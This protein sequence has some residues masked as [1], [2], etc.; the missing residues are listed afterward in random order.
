MPDHNYPTHIL[1]KEDYILLNDT[2]VL[3]LADHWLLR[4]DKEAVHPRTDNGKL[5]NNIIT[6]PQTDHLT[7]NLSLSLFGLFQGEDTAWWPIK[8]I[9]NSAEVHKEWQTGEEGRVPS[10]QEYYCE[11]QPGYWRISIKWLHGRKFTVDGKEYKCSIKHAPTVCNYW[12]FELHVCDP[13]GNNI[14]GKDHAESQKLQ[15]LRKKVAKLLIP[16][17][18][19]NGL[20]EVPPPEPVEFSESIYRQ[21]LIDPVTVEAEIVAKFTEQP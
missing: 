17:L 1:P 10:E 3:N 14:A 20:S 18:I 21:C 15:T 19:E 6:K 4:H 7:K 2:A 12:H 11:A 8:G 13:E 9:T 16:S 5:T